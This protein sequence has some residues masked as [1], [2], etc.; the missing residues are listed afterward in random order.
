MV[1]M[2]SLWE[3]GTKIQQLKARAVC[4]DMEQGVLNDSERGLW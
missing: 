4:V 3:G 1:I 2:K